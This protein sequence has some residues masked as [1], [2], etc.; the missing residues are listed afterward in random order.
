LFDAVD[1]E[2]L[3]AVLRSMPLHVWRS[4][5]VMPLVPHPNDPGRPS[6][7]TPSS[8]RS[9]ESREFFTFFTVTAPDHSDDDFDRA[10]QGEAARTRELAGQGFLLRL[11]ALPGHGK[12]LGLWRAHDAEAV[13]RLLDSLPLRD[14]FNV[15]TTPLG[16]HP[17]DPPSPDS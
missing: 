6:A 10:L 3:E 15:E 14:W 2:S 13:R 4:D 9:G 7:G 12:A 17:S 1:E 8:P 5:D 11:W 16:H